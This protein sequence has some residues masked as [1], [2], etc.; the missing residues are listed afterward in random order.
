MGLA[1]LLFIIL[2]LSAPPDLL[3]PLTGLAINTALDTPVSRVGTLEFM[4]PVRSCPSLGKHRGATQ[5]WHLHPD[6]TV[7]VRGAARHLRWAGSN[8]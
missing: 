3:A 1:F 7:H 5:P 8:P 6:T 2:A 4:A